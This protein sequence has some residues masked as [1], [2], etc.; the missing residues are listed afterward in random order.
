MKLSKEFTDLQKIWY[1]KLKKE[2]FNDIENNCGFSDKGS[3]R[4]EN[5]PYDFWGKRFQYRDFFRVIG[6]YAYHCPDIEERHKL[7]LIEYAECGSIPK[8]IERSEVNISK[9][10]MGHYIRKNTSKMLSFVNSMEEICFLGEY[11]W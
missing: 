7:V 2:G 5:N 9:R 3:P 8:A 4:Y 10:A 11:Q 1:K 6:L